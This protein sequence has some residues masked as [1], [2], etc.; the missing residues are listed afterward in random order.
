MRI[1]L[2]AGPGAGKS[3]TAARFFAHAKVNG[4]S[5]EHVTEYVKAWAYSGRKP[6]DFDQVYLFAKQQ[7]YEYRFLSNGVKN[8]VTDSPTFLSVCYAEMYVGEKMA[9]AI[10]E[11]NKM[12]GNDYPS[13]DVFLDR[14][15]KPYQQTGR[16]QTKKQAQEIDNRI[17]RI[18]QK[19]YKKS[20]IILDFDDF[21]FNDDYMLKQLKI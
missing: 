2:F 18:Y 19:Y 12:Y 1:N 20:P 3:T 16:F 7:Q 17:L 14:K 21:E 9:N 11:L 10:W 5:I 4:F 6:T 15:D 8:I 13:T